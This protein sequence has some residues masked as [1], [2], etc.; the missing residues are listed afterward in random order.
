M[1]IYAL[2]CRISFVFNLLF[3]AAAVLSYTS[4]DKRN[5]DFFAIALVGY[6]LSIFL[7]SPGINVITLILFLL[8][9]TP[10]LQVPQWLL[11]SN[12]AF[13]LFQIIFISL[14]NDTRYY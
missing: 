6:G 11:G 8:G 3:L 9:K 5:P 14:L 10:H 4:L 12:F 2:L 7:F 13:L 1:K